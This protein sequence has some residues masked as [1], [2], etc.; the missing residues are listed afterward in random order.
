MSSTIERIQKIQQRSCSD[1][2]LRRHK[3]AKDNEKI[4]Q[5]QAYNVKLSRLLQT[6]DKD[7]SADTGK[8]ND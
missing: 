2:S 1:D 4:K 5:N 6:K 7:Y 3:K 8:R